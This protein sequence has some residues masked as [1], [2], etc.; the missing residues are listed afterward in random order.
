VGGGRAA[1]VEK[2]GL[3]KRADVGVLE[4]KGMLNNRARRKKANY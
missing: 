4:W 2:T 1:I 3:Q